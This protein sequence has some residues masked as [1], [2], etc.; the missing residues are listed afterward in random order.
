VKGLFSGLGIAL[1]A[2][3]STPASPAAREGRVVE[4]PI[5]AVDGDASAYGY[6][7]NV[8]LGQIEGF[9][10][11]EGYYFVDIEPPDGG[12]ANGLWLIEIR[13]TYTGTSTR[14]AREYTAATSEVRVPIAIHELITAAA[15]DA[16]V[17]LQLGVT[18]F[19]DGSPLQNS[20]AG[21]FRN[22]CDTLSAVL[23]A[24]E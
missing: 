5:C 7:A 12:G 9:E 10:C 15:Q 2:S 11:R 19:A 16:Q 21:V 8:D 17:G 14:V 23:L 3:L 22:K 18:V 24:T 4:V 20:H 1:A 13:V 6:A